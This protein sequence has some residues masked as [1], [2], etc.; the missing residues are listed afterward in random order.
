MLHFCD[1]DCDLLIAPIPASSAG[2][3]AALVAGKALLARL[4]RTP[5]P[6]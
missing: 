2:M 6:A 3:R 1:S 4:R 5:A